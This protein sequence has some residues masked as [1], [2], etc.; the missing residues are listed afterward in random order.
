M[1]NRCLKLITTL[2][3][4]LPSEPKAVINT[5]ITCLEAF[6]H[7]LKNSQEVE[8]F[9]DLWIMTNKEIVVKNP[10][11]PPVNLAAVK[12]FLQVTSRISRI[13]SYKLDIAPNE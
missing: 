2:V 10:E 6:L 5:I 3:A 9:L 11:A 4:S 12:M 8:K 7:S 13:L 1:F